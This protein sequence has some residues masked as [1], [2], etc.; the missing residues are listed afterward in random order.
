[1]VVRL[2]TRHEYRKHHRVGEMYESAP[3]TDSATKTVEPLLATSWSSRLTARPGPSTCTTALLPHRRLDDRA[4]GQDAI[5]RT[6]KLGG[7]DRLRMGRG[8][9][10]R[11]PDQ[12]TLVLL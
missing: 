5:Q 10:D 6:I 1:M 12:Y 2:G 9:H 3:A 8:H 4:G 11:Q 7:G